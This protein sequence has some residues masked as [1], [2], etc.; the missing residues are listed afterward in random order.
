MSTIDLSR[1]PTP[2]LLDELSFEEILTELRADLLDRSPDIADVLQ[3]ESEPVNKLLEVVAYRE[4]ITRHKQNERV[5]RLL[6]AYSY[7]DALDHIGVTYFFT[8]RFDGESDDAYRRRLLLAPDRFSTAGA[9]AAYIYHALSA[10]AQVKDASATSPAATEVTVA[11]LAN[12]GNGTASPE[13]IETVENALN[14]EFVRPLTDRVT[15]ISADV[16]TYT[17]NAEL[18]IRPGPD[19][20]VVRAAAHA[21]VVEFTERRHRLGDDIFQDAVLA[22]LYV[23]GVERVRLHSPAADMPRSAIQAAYCTSIEVALHD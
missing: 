8:E 13:L 16:A 12:S 2:T 6:L 9:E 4:M 3:L 18:I 10:D 19:P 23:E 20:E 15:V 21:S 14:A 22:A 7:G 17:I 5:R 1:L 11:V